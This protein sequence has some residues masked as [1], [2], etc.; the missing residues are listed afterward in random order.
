[1]KSIQ[2]SYR[3]LKHLQYQEHS[4]KLHLHKNNDNTNSKFKTFIS[5]F[6]ANSIG[7]SAALLTVLIALVIIYIVTGHSKLKML[8]ANMALQCIKTVEAAAL[9][10][11]HIICKNGLV[12]I[13]MSINLAI[14][15]LMALAKLRKS[16]IFKGRLF[17]NTVKIKLFVADN[18]CYIPLHLNKMTG[19]VHLFK[20]HGMLI[21]ENLTLKNWIWDVLEIDWTDVYVIQNDKEINLPVTVVVPMYYK[22]KLRRLLRNSRRDSLNLYIMLKQRKSWFHLENTE[23]K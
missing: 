14:L 20:L 11:H 13:L 4:K 18:Q 16:K 22:F 12:R 7:F 6:I 9:N 5:S 10:P 15:I 2:A 23:C 21:K 8:V 19:S 3:H 17:S 1:M